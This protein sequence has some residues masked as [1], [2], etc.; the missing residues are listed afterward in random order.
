MCVSP[1]LEEEVVPRHWFWYCGQHSRHAYWTI[2]AVPIQQ[3][4]HRG[5]DAAMGSCCV[6]EVLGCSPSAGVARAERD[7]V[8]GL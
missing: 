3:A 4:E 8:V 6:P 5:P 2:L 7:I 1:S